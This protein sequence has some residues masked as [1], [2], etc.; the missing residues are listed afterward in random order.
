VVRADPCESDQT[1]IASDPA[2]N[3]MKQAIRKTAF[4]EIDFWKR[5]LESGL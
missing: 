3:M 4:L 2:V 5:L 1:E